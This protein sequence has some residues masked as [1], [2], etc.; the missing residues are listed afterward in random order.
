MKV[1][2]NTWVYG[3]KAPI[4]EVFKNLNAFGYKGVEIPG[5][6]KEVNWD[7]ETRQKVKN[8]AKK[9]DIEFATVCADTGLLNPV[10]KRNINSQNPQERKDAIAHS[11]K[12]IDLAKDIGAPIVV[13]CV[14]KTEPGQTEEMALSL[15]VESYKELVPYAEKK[16][17]V[18]AIES[19]PDR[20]AGHYSN[21]VK[22]CKK[23]N[24]PYVK[25]LID[26]GHELVMNVPLDKAVKIL[27]KE[28][29]AHVHIDNNNGVID[30][31]RALND[32]KLTPED[33][34]K[35]IDA[36]EEIGYEGWYSFELNGKDLDRDPDK[37]VKDSKEVLDKII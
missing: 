24:S 20:W 13:L 17:I 1:S 22:L 7:A 29:L 12:G 21:L 9:Y 11:K 14:G 32:G 16:N 18:I 28:Y 2:I 26:T 19:F 33:F 27:G 31:H 37:V 30:D 5:S 36:L 4:E 23:V 15:A 25:G 6:D 35:F 8:L 3:A 34:K 10:L